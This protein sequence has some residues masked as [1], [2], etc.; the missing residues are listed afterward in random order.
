MLDNLE[1]RLMRILLY[2]A[3]QLSTSIE[4]VFYKQKSNQGSTKREC[5]KTMIESVNFSLMSRTFFLS[6]KMSLI[7]H[8]DKNF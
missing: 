5:L 3:S 6:N 4:M 2:K 7:I 1:K 8:S